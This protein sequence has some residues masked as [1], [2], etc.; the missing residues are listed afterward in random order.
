M[1]QRI[2][3]LEDALAIL[4]SG[5]SSEKHPLLRDDIISI[6]YN[7]EKQQSVGSEAPEN[8]ISETM[9]AFG[10]MTIID[11]DE[12]RYFGATAGPEVCLPF[13]CT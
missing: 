12:S 1:S 13:L 7:P 11:K 5:V 10:T 4:Q 3:L 2:Q 8:S 6:N 9:E